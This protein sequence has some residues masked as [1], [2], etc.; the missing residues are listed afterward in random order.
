[1]NAQVIKN[2]ILKILTYGLTGIGFLLISSFLIL[3]FPPVQENLAN[4][5]LNDFSK[6]TGFKSTITG[7]RILWFDRLELEGVTILDPANSEMITAK[8]ILINY[9]FT[10][11]LQGKNVNIDGLIVDSAHVSIHRISEYDTS[12]NL[13]I[14]VFV[15]RINEAYAANGGS[16]KSPQINLGEALLTQSVFTFNDSKQDSINYG[17]DYNHFKVDIDEAQLQNFMIL[18]DT[19]EFNVQTLIAK[20]RKTELKIKQLS[21]FFRI[22]Q[23]AMEFKGLKLYANESFISDTVIFHYAKQTDLN[24]FNNLVTIEANLA[25]TIIE[26]S[27]IAL[28]APAMR[29]V[30]QPLH[31]SGK[32]NGKVNRFKVTRMDIGLGNTNLKGSIDLDGLPNTEET[33]IILNLS[34]SRIDFNDIAFLINENALNRLTPMGMHTL[35]GQFVGYPS[36]FVANGSFSSKVGRVTS[37]INFKLNEEDFNK[38]TYSGKLQLTD[39]DLGAYFNDTTTFQKINLNGKISGKGLTAQTADFTLDGK[40]TSIGLKGYNYSK[41]ETNA[42][43]ASE[44]FS[45]FLKIDDPNLKFNATGS[46][47]LRNNKNEIKIKASLDTSEFQNLKL[48][49]EKLSIRSQLDVNITGLDIDSLLG[50]AILKNIAI[51]YKDQ[52]LQ[53]KDLTLMSSKVGIEKNFSVNSS[54][55]NV[56]VNG[57]YYFTQ[58]FTDIQKLIKEL[59]LNIQNDQVETKKYYATQTFLPGNDY[60]LEYKFGIKNFN[61]ISELLNIDFF[62][63]P[64][65][66]IN[67]EFSHGYTTIFNAY[68]K[69]DTINIRG[70]NF[71]ENELEL[72][73][74]KIADSTNVLS[75]LYADSKNQSFK[76]LIANDLVLE[77]IWDRNHVDASLDIEQREKENYLRL[78]GGIDFLSDSTQL[79]L[80]PSDIQILKRKWKIDP[81]NLLLSKGREWNIK[82]LKFISG[83]ED[84]SLQGKISDNPDEKLTLE[85]NDLDLT[86]LN[87]FTTKK[88]EGKLDGTVQLSNFYAKQVIQNN[89][90]ID[91][92]YVNSFLVGNIEGTNSWSVA[93]E[94]FILHFLIDRLGDKI[95]NLEGHYDPAKES[96][97]LHVDAHL[98]KASLKIIEPFFDDIFSN[99]DGTIS[100][101]FKIKGDLLS[102][103]IRGEGD[104]ENG[105]IM[106]NY[107]QTLYKIKGTIGMTPTSIDFKNIVL[108]DEFNSTGQLSG[109]ILHQDFKQTRI[110]LAAQFKNFQVLKTTTKDNSL[111]YGEGFATGDVSFT[112]PVSNLKITA[113]ARTD[114]NTRIYIPLSGTS[115]GYSKKEFISFINF[116]DSAYIKENKGEEKNRISLTG[117]T[118]DLN[119]AITPDAYCELIFDIKSGDIIR[120]RG[121]GDIKLQ[122]DTK[123]EFNMFGPLEFTEGWYNFTLAGVINKEFNIERGSRITWFGDPYGAA[124]DIK[125][126]YN[127]M[128]SLSAVL[129]DPNLTS[130]P[131]ARRK[132]PVNVILN[133]DGPMLTSEINFDITA[134]N[135]PTSVAFTNPD[136]NSTTAVNLQFDFLAFKN[137]LDEQEMKRQVFSLLILRKLSPPESFD[138]SGAIVNSVSELLSNQLS[139]W[140][141]QVDD[142]LEIDVDLGTMD[143]EAFSTFQL[144]LSY[145]FLNGRMRITRD[146]TQNNQYTTTS[147]DVSNMVGDWTIDYLLTPDGK[148]RAKMYNRN[149]VNPIDNSLGKQ[150]AVTTGFSL[151]HTQNFNEFKELL[152]FSRKKSKDQ[153]PKKDEAETPDEALKEEDEN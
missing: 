8:K 87:A 31:I 105:Q 73:V 39:F 103:D 65:T 132:Y 90:F 138:T 7:L 27:D 72:T 9:S 41:I 135:L 94:K 118:F 129:T 25:N 141:T 115:S 147:N 106:I 131:Q 10:H 2:R 75:M 68:S 153:A 44:F 61:P 143:D 119:L 60:S 140:M 64:G 123:G 36:D 63:N 32:L 146:G 121:T 114:R 151:M 82:K 148:F 38:S 3:Q 57:D 126:S 108:T 6:K 128:T 84:I 137:R 52:E 86:V 59:E 125:A 33:F 4:R 23:R 107:L 55:I 45:G 11:L 62:V 54:L 22:S 80:L 96:D 56:E 99:L 124:L 136:D 26:P 53:L 88:I 47:D 51:Q 76:G 111:F 101:L 40:I 113:N 78:K 74:S 66:E 91:N 1:M 142:N 58:V 144:R 42:H 120:G 130:A 97:P 79:K 71:W 110:N 18:G 81:N 127:Q 29:K 109:S 95:V 15:N 133:I 122:L 92:L 69:I 67:G 46:I 104:I 50:T 37:D 149:N 34:D 49:Y 43:F 17:F 13:N 30:T 24:D 100:G 77:A 20:D 139:Y 19:T 85:V 14:N 83:D 152:Q 102:P 70:N 12:S 93:E 5:F 134:D 16:G 150:S 21:T 28:F 89:I 116:T 48:S 112:G 35:R 145:T 117:I 98:Q